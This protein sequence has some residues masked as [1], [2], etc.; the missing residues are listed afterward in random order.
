MLAPAASNIVLCSRYPWRSYPPHDHDSPNYCYKGHQQ[1]GWSAPCR[2]PLAV[3]SVLVGQLLGTF[4]DFL[5]NLLVTYLQERKNCP[6]DTR[7][8]SSPENS[9]WTKRLPFGR[10]RDPR[11]DF[12]ALLV[13]CCYCSSSHYPRLSARLRGL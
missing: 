12:H 11:F 10:F 5:F 4:S 2:G 9:T 6:E 13:G 8:L 1:Q 3:P 7:F